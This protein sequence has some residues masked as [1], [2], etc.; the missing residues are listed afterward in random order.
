MS[1]IGNVNL[2][3]ATLGLQEIQSVISAIRIADLASAR[4]RPIAERLVQPCDRYCPG[5]IRH[6]PYYC[7][8]PVVHPT[9]RYLPRPVI[10]PTPRYEPCPPVK[11]SHSSPP[12]LTPPPPPPWKTLPWQEPAVPPNVIKVMVRPPDIAGKGMLIDLFL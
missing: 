10:H 2:I 9:P 11:R 12:T 3:V 8:R 1:A 4:G 7:P 6:E 5:P